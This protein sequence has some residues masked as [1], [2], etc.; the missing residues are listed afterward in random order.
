VFRRG[1]LIIF[2]GWAMR[3]R[4]LRG[5]IVFFLV[6]EPPSEPPRVEKSSESRSRP[7][8]IPARYLRGWG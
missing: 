4:Y 7:T 6:V 1:K 2:S 3:A 5:G 8:S